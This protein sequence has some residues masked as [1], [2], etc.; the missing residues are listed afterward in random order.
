MKKTF[1]LFVTFLVGFSMMFTTTLFAQENDALEKFKE[2]IDRKDKTIEIVEN[3]GSEENYS[4]IN[5]DYPVIITGKNGSKFHGS[6]IIMSD[7]VT[8]QNLK[9]QNKGDEKGESTKNRSGIYV[10]AENVKLLNNSFENGLGDKIGL[11]N[12]VQIMSPT[13]NNK[14]ASY[15]L[16]NNTFSGHNNQ[17]PGF[18]SSAIVVAQGYTP[19]SIG[20]K[21]ARSIV[22][23]EDDVLSVFK[24]NVF[25]N[26]NIDFTHQD[27]SKS[28]DEVVLKD[29]QQEEFIENYKKNMMK[30]LMDEYEA[31]EMDLH[32]ES[33]DFILALEDQITSAVEA[34]GTIDEIDTVIET[35]LTK[36]SELVSDHELMEQAI[37]NAH[38]LK[39]EEHVKRALELV[40]KYHPEE[41]KDDAIMKLELLLENEKPEEEQKDDDVVLT[42][43]NQENKDKKDT[44][45]NGKNKVPHTG[46]GGNN[47]MY[48]STVV[49]S[50]I[51]LVKLYR[52]KRTL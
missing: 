27:W 23:S 50:L 20:S 18:V 8:I 3:I 44:D 42:P 25:S 45:N 52:R 5:I 28:Q 15:I 26:N 1:Y 6:F 9:I 29:I 30:K 35:I 46:V 11:S 14:F 22:V 34:A 43:D 33:Q 51:I 31:I 13:L 19:S 37:T 48:L 12:G 7:D 41:G 40:K 38:D 17:V 39:T 32:Q 21:E 36:I 2:S 16:E 47:V 24:Y 49:L 10:Y 4:V